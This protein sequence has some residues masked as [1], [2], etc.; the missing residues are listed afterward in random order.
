MAWEVI[1]PA[2]LVVFC[3]PHLGLFIW[4]FPLW[5][6]SWVDWR[7]L[8]NHK[9]SMNSN[10][11]EHK[12]T[13]VTFIR[14]WK[15]CYAFSRH[16]AFWGCDMPQDSCSCIPNSRA[17]Q[18]WGNFSPR[19]LLGAFLFLTIFSCTYTKCSCFFNRIVCEDSYMQTSPLKRSWTKLLTC[20]FLLSVLQGISASLLLADIHVYRPRSLSCSAILKLASRTV[21]LRCSQQ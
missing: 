12:T 17:P 6:C 11:K 14:R 18:G 5:Y 19:L 9:A 15:N 13:A 10:T 16:A 2:Y 7:Y 20:F 1:Q 3:H 8:G 4:F 21:S